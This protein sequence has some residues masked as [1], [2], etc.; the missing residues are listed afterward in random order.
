MFYGEVARIIIESI[1]AIS[2]RFEFKNHLDSD[3]S[4]MMI[5]MPNIGMGTLFFPERNGTTWCVRYVD[6]IENLHR[7]IV[8]AAEERG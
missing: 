1:S 4:V 3:L 6:T 2:P 8:D 7:I 5:T